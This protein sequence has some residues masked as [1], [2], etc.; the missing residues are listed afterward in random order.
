MAKSPLR[1]APHWLFRAAL[2]L[3]PLGL[4]L[5]AAGMERVRQQLTQHM[6]SVV[7][8][9]A[10]PVAALL[11]QDEGDL[12]LLGRNLIQ[13]GVHSRSAKTLLQDY[14][15]AAPT[16]DAISVVDRKG[17]ILASTVHV[18]PGTVEFHGL[19]PIEHF[20]IGPVRRD[21]ALHTWVIPVYE[22]VW[23]KGHILFQA[24]LIITMI[25]A[26]QF[27]GHL[28]LPAHSVTGVM[29]SDD[30][31]IETMWPPRPAQRYRVPPG[32][33]LA[34]ILQRYP[35]RASGHYS[36]ATG[37]RHITRIG[38]FARIGT[39]PL[40]AFMA[41]PE[42]AL[43]P[44]WF[45]QM[46]LPEGLL[47]LLFVALLINSRYL[48]A[49]E[50]RWALER[51][52]A[53]RQLKSSEQRARATGEA[54]GDGIIMTT[55]DGI[56]Q[57]MNSTAERLTGWSASEA[58]GASLEAVY[59]PL[60]PDTRD[61]LPSPAAACL[62]LGGDVKSRVLISTRRGIL[63]P[64][65]QSV[66][67]FMDDLG[68]PAGV[69]VAFEDLTEKAALISRLSYEASHDPLTGLPNRTAFY[70]EVQRQALAGGRFAVL[71]IDLN[72][73]ARV[74]EA[75]GQQTGDRAL[76]AAAE[77][78]SSQVTAP[79]TIA[80]Y[81][82]DDFAAILHC[83]TIEAARER[84]EQLI[85]AFYAPLL[86]QPEEVFLG[87]T[88]GLA[89]APQHGQD[90]DS[91]CQAADAA[92]FL[93]KR[94]SSGHRVAIF[95]PTAAPAPNRLRSLDAALH[96]ALERN[97][98]RVLYQPEIE[99]RGGRVVG[100]EAL[101]RWQHPDLGLVQPAQ[102]IPLAEQGGLILPIGRWVLET[103]CLQA[104]RWRDEI[105]PMVVGVNLSARQCLGR[106]LAQEVADILART[107][108]PAKALQ[109]EL[110]ESLLIRAEPDIVRNL[111]GCRE[112]GVSLAIDDFG[113][114]YSS[115][116]YLKHLPVDTLK[117]DHSFMAGVPQRARDN[118][119]V[120]AVVTIGHSLGLRIVAEGIETSAQMDFIR[121]AQCDLAQGFAIGR[122][123]PQEDF[124]RM[125][126]SSQQRRANTRVL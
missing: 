118:T 17:R 1:I 11:Q 87:I 38:A 6:M 53:A 83:A 101:I 124:G 81:G 60:H 111:E 123:M 50:T 18:R 109:L 93:A 15:H 90:A 121:R 74:N 95:Q 16:S 75:H 3:L 89:L 36:G 13:V 68:A 108:L 2:L 78:L 29:R 92:L 9:A 35:D 80:R 54:V 77:R 117:I 113:T 105:G 59:V 64:V 99:V 45:R 23:H 71:L 104:K 62:G 51:S 73:L 31:L 47:L 33:I 49:Q 20:E 88:I 67:A 40:V 8:A 56:I 116:S 84:A 76:I 32:G 98:L 79:E 102:F 63:L 10:N 86:E 120:Q 122:P 58:I 69:V 70:D 106:S 42:T 94:L 4:A 24:V 125:L 57:S 22:P 25:H 85:T 126:D 37:P 43:W 100:A 55:T 103:A 46:G 114:G 52:D 44:L 28:P 107:G 97:E 65:E 96:H 82:G 7:S 112:L 14:Q 39:L 61:R 34:Q 72:S 110:T 19:P 91:L 26:E 119:V 5:G 115:L 48:T 30:G 21:H 41:V 66:S 12:A 27:W